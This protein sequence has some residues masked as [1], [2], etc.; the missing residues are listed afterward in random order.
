MHPTLGRGR[1]P[2]VSCITRI[3]LLFAAICVLTATLALASGCGKDPY[4]GTWKAKEL[5]STTV[6]EKGAGDSYIV[7]SD[8]G[9]NTSTFVPDGDKLS[10]ADGS[11]YF[12]AVDG[13]L[14]YWVRDLPDHPL[15]MVRE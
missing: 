5:A 15:W 8:S 13:K 12:Q 6:I 14:K 11:E 2:E 7:R 9:G 1:R 10:T 4:L 3:S